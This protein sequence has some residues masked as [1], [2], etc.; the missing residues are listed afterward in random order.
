MAY[1]I[2]LQRLHVPVKPEHQTDNH[3]EAGFAGVQLLD[4][5]ADKQDFL[6][7]A[8]P[9]FSQPRAKFLPDIFSGAPHIPPSDPHPPI[10]GVR[11]GGVS[12]GMRTGNCLTKAASSCRRTTGPIL[13]RACCHWGVSIHK[14]S[15]YPYPPPLGERLCSEPI[16]R[17]MGLYLL[18]ESIYV[19]SNIIDP[20]RLPWLPARRRLCWLQHPVCGGSEERAA[21]PHRSHALRLLNGRSNKHATERVTGGF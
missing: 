18:H 14:L 3:Q 21:A 2:N 6:Q 5:S 20:C 9:R 16:L 8:G 4:F 1:R 10:G 19:G 12:T 7:V 17:W 15:R 11:R 13:I